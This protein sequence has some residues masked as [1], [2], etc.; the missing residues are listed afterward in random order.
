MDRKVQTVDDLNFELDESDIAFDPVS[1]KKEG[2]SKRFM[3]LS[4]MK[5]QSSEP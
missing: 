1:S 4:G 2:S 3:E 5:E